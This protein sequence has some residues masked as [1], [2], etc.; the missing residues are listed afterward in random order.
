MNLLH[1]A[2][3]FLVSNDGATAV[4]Y[5]VM[6]ALIII[7]FLTSIQTVGTDTSATRTNSSA[8]LGGS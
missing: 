5:V 4:E 7:I 6:L 3:R 8:K 2:K 1:S